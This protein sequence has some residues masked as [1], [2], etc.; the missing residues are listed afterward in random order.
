MVTEFFCNLQWNLPSIYLLVM[1]AFKYHTGGMV[2]NLLSRVYLP[3]CSL[4]MHVLSQNI[5]PKNKC[6]KT[7]LAT[8]IR[9][10]NLLSIEVR[11]CKIQYNVV[12]HTRN[13]FY[14]RCSFTFKHRGLQCMPWSDKILSFPSWLSMTCQ[15][16]ITLGI[17]DFI[18]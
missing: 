15:I 8:P 13:Q 16:G 6:K 2:A 9:F 3:I 11:A 10:C 5:Q 12:W 7:R 4:F 17:H 14:F 1:A 18:V